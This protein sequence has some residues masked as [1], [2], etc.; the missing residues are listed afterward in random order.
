MEET[1]KKEP[2]A[3]PAKAKEP[4]HA[5]LSALLDRETEFK[6]PGAPGNVKTAAPVSPFWMQTD[7]DFDT[8]P[9][10]AEKKP[11]P[12]KQP[13][14]SD[15]PDEP[16]TGKISVRLLEGSAQTAAGMVDLT[17]KSLLT[18]IVAWKFTQRLNKVFT[19]KEQDLIDSKLI[20]A[21]MDDLDKEEKRIKKRFESMIQKYEKKTG[22][23]PQTDAEKKQLQDCFY[24]YFEYTQQTMSPG[25]YLGMG[26]VDVVGGKA[27]DAL[28]GGF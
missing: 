11:E 1:E 27:I 8:P 15:K 17:T 7:D 13:D 20:D 23:I 9:P 28:T 26:I 12:D 18:P 19:E 24:N 25:W 16:A 22:K 3:A 14:G 2:L 6:A 5:D 21:E 10:V 4:T